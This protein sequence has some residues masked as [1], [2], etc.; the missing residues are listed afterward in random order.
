MHYTDRKTKQ[1]NRHFL[2]GNAVTVPALHSTLWDPTPI[3]PGVS[4][5]LVGRLFPAGK[6]DWYHF[7][8]GVDQYV[9]YWLVTAGL[10][11]R[12]R[13]RGTGD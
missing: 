10:P 7:R 8:V 5:S 2:L 3:A 12:A 1:I 13:A 9:L 6:R 11:L 4:S